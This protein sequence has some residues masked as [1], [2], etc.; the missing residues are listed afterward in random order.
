MLSPDQ[1]DL[2]SSARRFLGERAPSLGGFG[3]WQQFAELGWLGVALDEAH[4][5]F[6][7][8]AEM[9]VLAQEIASAL[10]PEPFLQAAV[11]PAVFL[12]NAAPCAGFEDLLER[13][14]AGGTAVVAAFAE[15]DIVPRGSVSFSRRADGVRLV[16]ELPHVLGGAGAQFVLLTAQLD[17]DPNVR[18]IFLA[19]A[20]SAG[21]QHSSAPTIDGRQAAFFELDGARPAA[22]WPDSA[23]A[24][25]AFGLAQDAGLLGQCAELL[26]LM[27]RLFGLTRDYL[28]ERRQFG[29]VLAEFQA[30]RHRLADMYAEL[31]QA[32][33]MLGVG[34]DAMGLA[35]ASAR[36]R[37]LSACKLRM[38]RAARFIGAQ[39]IQLHGAIALTQEYEVG[40]LYQRLLVLE[41]TWGDAEF[42]ARRFVAA[43]GDGNE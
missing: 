5:G 11:V 41:K 20:D 24:L 10:A 23:A 16:G 25:A 17:V 34:I 21:V 37:L 4:G 29:Q 39:S 42:H 22:V 26:G 13:L 36:A 27:Q 12:A 40:R 8:P 35:T 1:R 33:A 30:L 14:I 7:G 32:R 6:G 31:E 15:P 2:Q 43:S 38:A 18:G 9:T 28:R 19:D 3:R